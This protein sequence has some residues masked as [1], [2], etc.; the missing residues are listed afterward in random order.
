VREFGVLEGV[1][2]DLD[3]VVA[4]PV[5]VPVWHGNAGDLRDQHRLLILLLSV[6][7]VE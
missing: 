7:V 4:E 6:L 1:Q 2:E 5:E 3:V